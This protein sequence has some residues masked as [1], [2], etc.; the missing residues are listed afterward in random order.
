MPT[1]WQLAVDVGTGNE[2]NN[3]ILTRDIQL[4]AP[5]LQNTLAIPT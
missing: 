2:K 5:W 4:V 1:F 3:T